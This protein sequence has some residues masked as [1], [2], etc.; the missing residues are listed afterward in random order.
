MSRHQHGYS[1]VRDIVSSEPSRIATIE[2]VAIFGLADCWIAGGFVRSAIWDALFPG[3]DA[4]YDSDVDVLY[5]EPGSTLP[6]TDKRRSEELSRL[7]G[8]RVEVKNQARM[9]TKNKDSPYTS[10]HQALSRWTETCT[11]VG[12]RSGDA[13]LEI[14]A[15]HGVEDLVAGYIRPTST[16]EWVL[17]L[18]AHRV[19][20]KNWLRRWHGLTIDPIIRGRLTAYLASLDTMR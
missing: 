19:E 12:I 16:E 2:Q 11:A 3:Y 7:T 18:V 4:D 6:E 10:T 20:S 17:A 9:H 14:M 13:E 8:L 5:F 1:L 15:P